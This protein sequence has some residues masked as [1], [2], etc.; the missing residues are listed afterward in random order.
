[1]KALFIRNLQEWASQEFT[2]N[3]G[4]RG[5]KHHEYLAAL[6]VLQRECKVAARDN[7]E[8]GAILDSIGLTEVAV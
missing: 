1:M 4:G 5:W 6:I 3:A 8:V 2:T 7:A